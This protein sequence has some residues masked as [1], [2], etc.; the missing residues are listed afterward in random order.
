MVS[1]VRALPIPSTFRVLVDAASPRPPIAAV[2]SQQVVIGSC[3]CEPSPAPLSAI[4]ASNPGVGQRF[5]ND[6]QRIQSALSPTTAT[7]GAA[8]TAA[9]GGIAIGI[10][11]GMCTMMMVMATSGASRLGQ[12]LDARE[13]TALGCGCKVR[14]KLV[15]LVR[16]CRIPLRLRSL[17]GALQVSGDLLGNLLVL[18]WVRLLELFGAC[19]SI[20][21]EAK[22]G[23]CLAA[24]PA[25]P[26]RFCSAYCRSGCWSHWRS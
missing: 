21:R 4:R 1:R 13:L 24:M 14:R 18:G 7:R 23:C 22:V 15:E 25:T 9:R 17:R 12:I 16:R 2:G 5:R 6:A 26:K 8:R 19:S 20:A 11:R 3:A 10:R